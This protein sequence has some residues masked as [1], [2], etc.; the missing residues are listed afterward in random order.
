[1]EKFNKLAEEQRQV[2]KFNQAQR[3]RHQKEM[4]RMY[5][6]EEQEEKKKMIATEDTMKD[7]KE[8]V[9]DS[10]KKPVND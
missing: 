5:E 10:D 6:M 9:K 1:M 7:A 4:R 3:R 8:A 2:R